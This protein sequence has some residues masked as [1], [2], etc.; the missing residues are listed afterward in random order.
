M[1]CLGSPWRPACWSLIFY[2]LFLMSNP[3][4][5]QT[6]SSSSISFGNVQVGS[7]LIKPVVITNTT[8]FNL[9]I[10]QAVVPGASFSFAGPTLPIILAP[11]KTTSLSVAF[12]PPAAGSA[13]GTLTVSS[14][15]SSNGHDQIHSYSTSIALSGTG[16]NLATPGYLSAPSSMNLGSIVIGTSKTQALTLSNSGGSDLTISASTVNGTGFS[17]IGLTLPYT[18]AAGSSASLSVKFAPTT[19]GTDNATLTLSSNASDSSVA[20][21]LSG[22]ATTS[23][24]TLG[25][26][27]GSMSFG[28]MTIGTSQSQKGSITASGASVTVSSTSSSNSEFTLSGLLLPV[29]IAAGQSVPFTVTFTPTVAGTASGTISF[30]SS[31]TTMAAENASGAGATVQHTIDLSW[32]ASTSTSVSGYNV[33]RSIV[34]GGPYTKINPSLNSSMN[35][36]DS[37]VQSG[38]AYYYVTTAVSSTGAES[39]YSNQ[40]TAVVPSP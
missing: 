32:N 4:T 10:S 9:T 11:Q 39:S 23:T 24:A 37:T 26:T 3:A 20:I 28:T 38:K 6:A 13:T 15:A 33:Y 12:T 16:Y 5:G 31:G 18:L 14:Y 7:S 2:S 30:I 1:M 19:A 29:T 34:T 21:S 40:V 8:K 27:P 22:T 36:S 35:Y 25:V 17:V